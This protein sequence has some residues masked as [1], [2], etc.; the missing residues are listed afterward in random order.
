MLKIITETSTETRSR[1]NFLVMWPLR[2]TW[3]DVLTRRMR[4]VKEHQASEGDERCMEAEDAKVAITKT[5]SYDYCSWMITCSKFIP[6]NVIAVG[7]APMSLTKML[8][9][10]GPFSQH[11]PRVNR[12]SWVSWLVSQPFSLENSLG[13]QSIKANH[14]NGFK[15]LKNQCKYVLSL[16]LGLGVICASLSFHRDSSIRSSAKLEPV[17]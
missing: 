17:S 16:H 3:L 4:Q 8:V 9:T 10:E 13:C 11:S 7:M 12:S 15:T 1:R 5:K 6:P 14:S 2:V